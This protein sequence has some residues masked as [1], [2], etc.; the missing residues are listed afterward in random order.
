MLYIK[1]LLG[2]NCKDVIRLG[3]IVDIICIIFAIQS[4]VFE[5]WFSLHQGLKFIL[6]ILVPTFA[7]TCAIEVSSWKHL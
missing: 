3:I 2:I 4:F 5:D 1:E 6:M 7:I